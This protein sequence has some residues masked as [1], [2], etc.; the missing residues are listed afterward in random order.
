MVFK[1][2][3]C[4]LLIFLLALPANCWCQSTPL[5]LGQ[6]PEDKSKLEDQAQFYLQRVG[7][8]PAQPSGQLPP[9]ARPMPAPV[10]EPAKPLTAAA[11]QVEE[12]SAAEKRAAE[13]GLNVKQ[14]GYSF[15][16]KPP[17][18][19]LP[20]QAVP[21][22]PDYIIGPG[23]TI[24]IIIWG[25]VQGEY[26]LAVDRNGQIP[27]PKVGVVQVS[28]LTYRQLRE[29]L[30]QEF[31]RQYTNFQMNVTLDNLRTIQVYVVGQARFPGSYAVSSL[32]TLVS[33]LFAAGGPS[34]SG[35]MRNVQVR[36][37]KK[38]VAHF[39]MY[40]FLIKG[41]KSRDIR[42]QSEDVI[43]IPPIGPVA[44][45][46]APTLEPLGVPAEKGRAEIVA[47]K[48][49]DP[50]VGGP[51]KVPGI[52]ELKRERTLTD[53]LNLAGGLADTAFKGRVQVL[54]VQQHREM[55]LFEDDLNRV[56]AGKVRDISLVDGD[57]VKIF[58][59]PEV[60]EKK[61]RLAG[62]VKKPGEFGLFDNMRVKD[63]IEY[64]GGLLMEANQQEAEITRVTITPQGPETTRIYVSP[65]LALSGGARDNILLKP[66]D[67]VFIRSIPEW[68]LYSVVKIEGEVKFPGNYS[69]KK[70]EPL[71][72][73]LGRA[74]GFTDKA[75]TKGA[76]FTRQAVKK[77]Q[78]E[79]LQ[80]IVD[81]LEAELYATS[82]AKTEAALEKEDA[83]RQKLVALQQQKFIAKMRTIVPLGRVVIRLD[84]PERLR[85][86][87]DDLEMQEGDSL[88][89]PQI[90]Q[91][92]NVMGSVMSPTAVIYNP[93]LTVA[94]YL[95]QAGGPSK[96]A[97]VRYIYVIKA[98]GSA[99]SGRGGIF[100]SG[101]S[102][103]RLDPGDTI[104]V[105]E[106]F[107]RVAWLK[108]VK[109]LTSIL[110]NVA[111]TAGV[112]LVGLKR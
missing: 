31:A 14:F 105:P 72:S 107:E 88:L 108:T 30:D 93:H 63:L 13:Y 36:R 23:D 90:Q 73:V 6:Q 35:S 77:M 65:R 81:R 85:G 74:G 12:T 76:F 52:F 60:I 100:F 16:Y 98:N 45:I 33:A 89:V 55:V 80:Q 40:D 78:A 67:Y 25:S 24:K 101:I 87:P 66:N 84:D 1:K 8:Q 9:Q 94:D 18:T 96:G 79:H 44:A 64:A 54:R 62:A 71:S 38:V 43:F 4:L 56:L 21:V 53:L 104:V 2:I 70:G 99:L 37:G 111:L 95:T 83:E 58:R 47:A 61:V 26:N 91:S 22:G 103:A 51:I 86:T 3:I 10:P 68:S 49:E 50:V 42:L 34:K 7:P 59:V 109:D 102:S 46:G 29:V 75:Y 27:I 11:R 106:N 48:P 57:F 82:A 17:E 15:F 28:G 69:I 41:D 19:F 97:D 5:G 110:A 112:V 39:D 92:V 32:S 20:V